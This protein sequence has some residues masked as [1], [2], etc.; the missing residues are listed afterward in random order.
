VTTNPPTVNPTNSGGFSATFPVPT[1]SEIGNQTVVATQGDNSALQTFAVTE[2]SNVASTSRSNVSTFNAPAN[3]SNTTLTAPSS[4]QSNASVP[5]VTNSNSLDVAKSNG[6]KT[7]E[8]NT[9]PANPS[10]TQGQDTSTDVPTM[11]NTSIL[12]SRDNKINENHVSSASSQANDT[13]NN[14]KKTDKTISI[15]HPESKD[16][17]T[18]TKL[19]N[20]N[21][22][23]EN[24]SSVTEATKW[25]QF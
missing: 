25:S 23:D 21:S 4:N 8:N 24:L 22:N 12:T 3:Q 19:T 15:S 11:T 1:S 17:L 14:K 13:S 2:P 5:V 9:A 7:F 16:Q 6:T 18:S 10:S 20:D